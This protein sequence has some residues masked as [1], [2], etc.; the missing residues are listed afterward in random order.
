MLHGTLNTVACCALYFDPTT[1]CCELSWVTM[2]IRYLFFSYYFSSSLMRILCT[3]LFQE[4]QLTLFFTTCALIMFMSIFP[5]KDNCI[6]IHT[7]ISCHCDEK[8]TQQNG[9]S[10]WYISKMKFYIP[11][12]TEFYWWFVVVRCVLRYLHKDEV[13]FCIFY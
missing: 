2:C 3:W 6:F 11:L 4:M 12:L 7:Y 1:V 5:L 8:K 10:D 9:V 13:F